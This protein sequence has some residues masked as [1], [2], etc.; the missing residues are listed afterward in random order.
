MIA[1]AQESRAF[2]ITA[3]IIVNVIMTLIAILGLLVQQPFVKPEVVPYI[4]FIAAILNIVLKLWFPGEPSISQWADLRKLYDLVARAQP[5]VMDLQRMVEDERNPERARRNAEL[6]IVS[7]DVV[8]GLIRE[9]AKGR[10]LPL[11]VK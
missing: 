7:I 8:P 2:A 1:R 3:S 9:V 6:I 4:V 11:T 10:R 5:D